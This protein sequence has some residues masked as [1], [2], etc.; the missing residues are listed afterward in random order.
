MV[1]GISRAIEVKVAA[2]ES[3]WTAAFKLVRDNYL[4]SGYEAPSPKLFRFTPYHALP[5]TTVFVAKCEGEV[6]AT[7]T[8][9]QD[10]HPLGLPMESLYEQE[11]GELRAQGRRL[12][13]VTSLAADGLSQREFLQVFI[14]L[15]RLMKQ[16][17]LEQ[18]GDTWVITVN[19]RHRSFYCKTLGYA[20]LGPARAYDAVGGAPAEAYW[21]D[22]PR[23]VERGPRAAES[24]F[25]PLPPETLLPAPMPVGL[26]RKLA[27]ESSQ[28][29]LGRVDELLN[30]ISGEFPAIDVE[31]LLSRV[32]GQVNVL[33][34]EEVLSYV[35][36][37]GGSRRW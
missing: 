32:N 8:L 17:H 35:C 3:E 9:V 1:P 31:L 6:V 23:M 36:H 27:A 7:F 28:T 10:N 15:I 2:D 22:Q 19:P 20:A 29:D 4:E 21:V 18:G 33:D 25:A 13:E 12:G 11:I 34:T 26:I 14:S 30:E 5:D 24:I 37:N 16:Y